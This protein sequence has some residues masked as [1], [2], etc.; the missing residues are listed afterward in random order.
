M[1]AVL[2]ADGD[3]K[4]EIAAG[5]GESGAHRNA[6]AKVRLY[7]LQKGQ[8]VEEVVLAPKTSRSEIAA[9]LPTK[10]GLFL[11]WFESKYMVKT[12]RATQSGTTW[13]LT[14]TPPVR[15]ATNYALGDLDG[16]GGEDLVVARVYGDTR[17]ADGDAFLLKNGVE[18]VPIPTTRGARSVVLADSDG[19]GKDEVFL[20]DGWHQ[21]YGK[22]ARARLSWSRFDGS[23]FQTQLLEESPGQFTMARLLAADLDGNR[24][25]EIISQGSHAVRVYK[26]RGATWAGTTVAGMTRDLAVVDGKLMVLGDKVS[27]WIELKGSL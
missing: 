7:R 13:T 12:A 5:W 22:Y 17:E 25:R 23:A 18:R 4:R 9:L 20:A 11:A 8:L 1:L 3:R 10:D 14:E 2:D 6:P 16:D 15:M 19:D 26:R 24:R 27:E 21:N